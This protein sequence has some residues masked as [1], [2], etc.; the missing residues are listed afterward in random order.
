MI[1]DNLMLEVLEKFEKRFFL[2]AN[3]ILQEEF[4]VFD[5]S[6]YDVLKKYKIMGFHAGETA[7]N[8]L[9]I[10]HLK[11][12]YPDL[13]MFVHVNPIFC[14]PGLVSEAVF[15]RVEK[16]VGVPIVSITYD[17]TATTK[18]DLLVPYLHFIQD[19]SRKI[20]EAVK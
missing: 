6:A 19:K 13:A 15:E 12:Q 1:R 4:P 18:N 9:K 17:G 5:E 7:Q 2:I 14:C 11:E 10:Y 16:E 8:I 3:E 20:A